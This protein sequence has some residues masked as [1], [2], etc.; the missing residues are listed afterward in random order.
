MV[1][2]TWAEFNGGA[3]YGYGSTQLGYVT[4]FIRVIMNGAQSVSNPVRFSSTRGVRDLYIEGE[5]LYLSAA[6]PGGNS[7]SPSTWAH[8]G[9]FTVS[10]NTNKFWPSPGYK[11]YETT[12]SRATITH[13]FI[14]RDPSSNYPGQWWMYVKS[15]V[16][17]R[18]SSGAYWFST[19]ADLPATPVSSGWRP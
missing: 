5:R 6:Y 15:D 14:W 16:L 18:Q 7:V 19:D 11:S 10:A 1:S 4:L 9:P 2:I 17:H 12:V 8:V 3:Y 13:E